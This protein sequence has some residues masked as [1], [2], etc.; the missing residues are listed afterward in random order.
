MRE[1][2]WETIRFIGQLGVN[3]NGTG[4]GEAQLTSAPVGAPACSIA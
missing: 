1:L 3:P 4:R 2:S